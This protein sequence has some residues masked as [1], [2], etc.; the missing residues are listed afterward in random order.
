[1]SDRKT[2]GIEATNQAFRQYDQVVKPQEYHL[3]EADHREVFD[4]ETRIPIC[5]L[6]R[7]LHG[8][9]T[10]KQAFAVELGDALRRLGFAILEG[11][12]VDPALY[13]EADAR[14]LE[15]FSQVPLED[16]MRHRAQRFGSVNQGYFPIKET[17]DIHPDLVEGWVFCRRA[18]DLDD[19]PAYQESDF[20]P[21]PGFEPIFRRVAE[22][23]G[24]L[25]L[26]VMQSLLRSLGCDP[27]L[28][29]RRLTGTNFGLRLNYYPPMS[30]ADEASGGGRMLGHEDVDLFTFLPASRVEGLQVL[31]RGNGKWI[32]LDAPRG[33][34]ILNT[35]DY[36]QR[37]S[38]DVFP[39]TTHRVSPPREL[40]ERRQPRVSLPM[41]IYLW[42]DEVLE[43]LPGLEPPKYEP[44]KA[45]NFHTRITSKYYGDDYAVG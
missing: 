26:P 37:I 39:S 45:I 13:D 38:N 19:D 32:R 6:G 5:D 18:F 25:I 23:H 11:H 43:V 33:S 7:F 20:W 44:I 1:M 36:V 4:E 29:D 24:R 16:K 15:V 27:H 40:T 9:E 22:A 21:R 41:A 42:E 17:T 14:I 10:D 34:I 31:N 30:A 8:N 35:G 3:A 2:Q 28:Y 12:G